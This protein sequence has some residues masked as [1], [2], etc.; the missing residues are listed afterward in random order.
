MFTD[1]V[2]LPVADGVNVTLM[3]QVAFTASVALLA[4]H[5]LV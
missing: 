2:R 5:V 1:A 4:G 3:E